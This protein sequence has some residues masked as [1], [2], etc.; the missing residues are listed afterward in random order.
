MRLSPQGTST[1]GPLELLVVDPER[2]FGDCLAQCLNSDSAAGSVR[3]VSSAVEALHV[4]ESRSPKG[5]VLG[6]HSGGWQTNFLR[7]ATRHS[8]ELRV[9]VL[10][11]PDATPED[12]AALV[13]AGARGCARTDDSLDHV[14]NVVSQVSAGQWWLP[15]A[16]LGNVVRALSAAVDDAVADRLARLT[17]RERQVLAGMA[18]GLPRAEIALRLNVSVNTVRTHVQH[19]LAKLGVNS[20]LEAAALALHEGLGLPGGPHRPGAFHDLR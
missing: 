19:L 1:E 17:F 18:E 11:A 16:L 9:V 13:A 20:S 5:M 3:A 12:L 8:P 14:R 15:R 7:A 10:V 6:A 2:A 4:L